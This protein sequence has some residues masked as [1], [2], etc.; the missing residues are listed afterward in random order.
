MPVR[1]SVLN[2]NPNVQ[3]NYVKKSANDLIPPGKIRLHFH[4]AQVHQS[5]LGFASLFL[6]SN[7][8]RSTN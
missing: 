4:T 3:P 2:R 5:V 7:Q 8:P 1:L 6:I